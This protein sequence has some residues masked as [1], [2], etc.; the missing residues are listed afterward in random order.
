MANND[1]YLHGYFNPL[2]FWYEWEY[3]LTTSNE[4][5]IFCRYLADWQ[6]TVN[7]WNWWIVG[8]K[9]ALG[10][11]DP[12]ITRSKD[13]D[14]CFHGILNGEIVKDHIKTSKN[15]TGVLMM[16]MSRFPA[17]HVS[18]FGFFRG[19][20]TGSRWL[21]GGFKHEFYFSIIYGMSSFPLTNSTIFQDG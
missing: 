19:K 14:V 1:E 2:V 4:F 9:P 12:K 7:V 17:S 21:V 16:L 13:S 6:C 11:P 10:W 15:T 18:F 20:D 3:L 8:Q 5:V